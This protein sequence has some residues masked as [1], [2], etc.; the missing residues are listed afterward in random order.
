M[1]HRSL[2]IKFLE[3]KNRKKLILLEQ[4]GNDEISQMIKSFINSVKVT[5]NSLASLQDPISESIAA[6]LDDTIKKTGVDSG[7]FLNK[8]L[9]KDS[10]PINPETIVP[11]AITYKKIITAID[12]TTT[13]IED[14]IKESGDIFKSVASNGGS[15]QDALKA[16]VAAQNNT[17]DKDKISVDDVSPEQMKMIKDLSSKITT[18]IMNVFKKANL[19]T[20]LTPED[21]LETPLMSFDSLSDIA[22]K[23][24][25]V[26]IDQLIDTFS[27]QSKNLDSVETKND[28]N[29]DLPEIDN[30]TLNKGARKVALLWQAS[31]RNQTTFIKQLVSAGL[32][33]DRLQTI[34]IK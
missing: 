34:Q 30:E 16:F 2:K 29:N 1:S 19:D 4:E 20:D 8:I 22:D 25:D 11:L 21:L 33:L 26:E 15:L 31:N 32:D 14:L 6:T 7:G 13:I 27:K 17:P 5:K 23:M 9:G 28:N 12:A 18:Q 3:R 24:D 10:N